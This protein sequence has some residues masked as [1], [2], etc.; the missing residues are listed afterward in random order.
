MFRICWA[1]LLLAAM[2]AAGAAARDPNPRNPFKDAMT[3]NIYL[4]Q[5]YYIGAY[6]YIQCWGSALV[7]P[8]STAEAANAIAFYYNKTKA[9]QP[10]TLRASRPKFHTSSH[11]VCP[12]TPLK[13]GG[14]IPADMR[15]P[16]QVGLL[17]HKLSKVLAKDSSKYTMRVGAGMRYTELLQEA[18]K[19]GMSV[20]L[21]TPTAYAGL[22]LSG[23][24]A[25]TAHG[26][27]DKTTSGI[28][29]TLLE[30]TWVDGTGKV[31]VSK[32]SDPEFRGM[33]GGMGTYGVMTE[34]LMQMTPPSYTELITVKK[35]DK[36]MFK[37][38][39]ELL[40]ITPHILI[41]WRPDVSSFVAYMLKP[42]AKGAKI[43]KNVS[44]TLLPD[45]RGQQEARE[46]FKIMSANMQDDS[47]AF[48]FLC[49]LQTAASLGA[50]WG[51]VNGKGVFNVT[52]PT[53]NLMASECDE[54]CNWNDNKVFFGTAQD[55]EFT[56][57]FSQ[58]ESWISDV[59]KIF[60]VELMEN[61]KAKYR[62]M[63]PGYLWIRFGSGYDGFTATNAGMQR[64]VFLQSTW[65]R[66]RDVLN[67]PS[68]YQYVADLIEELTLCKYNARP[69]WGKNFD[70]TFTHPRC[71]IRAKYPKFDQLLQ[72]QQQHDPARMFTP[73][74]F[75]RMANKQS[76]TLSPGCALWQGCYCE[77]DEN[78]A[79]DFK[80]VRAESF[81]EY[82]VCKPAVRKNEP[83]SLLPQI[84]AAMAGKH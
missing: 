72:L 28:W 82:R 69:H 52:G 61:G 79:K 18:E 56:A 19:A 55:V 45:V 44:M 9:G 23:V 32:P 11:F 73:R 35:S 21:G 81:P 8:S 36:E 58:L 20:Q 63:G 65:L 15:Q 66:S 51:S 71:G 60:N 84:F 53:N 1:A 42:A 3:R 68:R 76:Y 33:V 70:R 46:G 4:T 59:K 41:F 26:S 29:D 12:N 5:N 17:N 43:A 57:E 47:D 30:I 75:S 16:L 50:F 6:H 49:P 62:C 78:C 37:T 24:L 54:H 7:I 64:P 13:V 80:C 39:N 48:E 67:R 83:G 31:H 2:M 74:L 77:K 40:K 38:I 10:V 22:T 34:F 14:Q 25:T 27:G